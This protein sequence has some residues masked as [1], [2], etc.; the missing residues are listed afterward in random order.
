MIILYLHWL[1][2]RS[3]ETDQHFYWFNDY[4]QRMHN[5]I[6]T[7]LTWNFLVFF[8]HVYFCSFQTSSCRPLMCDIVLQKNSSRLDINQVIFH[9]YSLLIGL[10]RTDAVVRDPDKTSFSLSK[11]SLIAYW[12]QDDMIAKYPSLKMEASKLAN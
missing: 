5:N 10:I 4:S 8:I 11:G 1:V 6:I 2:N 12:T 7:Y 3:S 9:E